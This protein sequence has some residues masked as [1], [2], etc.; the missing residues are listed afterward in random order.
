[1]K[2]PNVDLNNYKNI[3]NAISNQIIILDLDKNIVFM[4]ESA[5]SLVPSNMGPCLHQPCNC[6]HTPYC[7]TSDCCIERFLRGEEGMIQKGPDGIANRVSISELKNDQGERIGYISISTDIRE[8]LDSQRQLVINEERYKIALTQSKSIL[9]R[10]DPYDNT[11]ERINHSEHYNSNILSNDSVIE[12]IPDSLWE[13]GA[14]AQES[15]SAV[16]TITKNIRNGEKECECTIK[17]R[18]INGIDHWIHIISTTIF[19]E[20]GMVV[21]AIGISKDV[22]KEKQLELDY[23]EEK[24]YHD[25]ISSDFIS[26][27]E[28]DLTTNKVLNANQTWLRELN[29]EKDASYDDLQNA[30]HQLLHP[31]FHYLKAKKD[32]QALIECFQNGEKQVVCEYRKLVDGNYRWIRSSTKLFQH[33]TSGDIISCTSMK[34]IE[35]EKQREAEWRNK[36]ERDLLTGV[37]NHSTAVSL[38]SNQLQRYPNELHAFIIMDLD[39]F[40]DVNDTYGHLYG[41][42]VLTKVAKQLL[43]TFE[44]S[45]IGRLGGDEFVV[46][47]SCIYDKAKIV[48][49]CEALCER[50]SKETFSH[51]E[52]AKVSVSIGISYYQERMTTFDELYRKADIAMY[53]GKNNGKNQCTVYEE[54]MKE[55]NQ[56]AKVGFSEDGQGPIVGN[57]REFIFKNLFTSDPDEFE[58]T[59]KNTLKLIAIYFGGQHCFIIQCDVQLGEATMIEEWMERKEYAYRPHLSS[60]PKEELMAAILEYQK[61]PEGIMFANDTTK[62]LSSYAKAHIQRTKSKTMALM[63]IPVDS[64]NYLVIGFCDLRRTRTFT[65]QQKNDLKTIYEIIGIF[66]LNHSQKL[67]LSDHLHSMISLLDHIG[68][69]VYVIDPFDH[70]LIYFNEET[71]R[72]FPEAGHGHRCYSCF[73]GFDAPCADCPVRNLKEHQKSVVTIYNEAVDQWVRTTASEIDWPDGHHYILLSCVDVTSYKNR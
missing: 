5:K 65:R 58:R 47:L 33:K 73:R 10:Y 41:D 12:R 25:I 67:K 6:F 72:L 57:I 38:I 34:D 31:E 49:Q 71:A 11:I 1:M 39:N 27:Y 18:D 56:I 48:H 35:D 66:L 52:M 46:F 21:E 32:K 70:H 26:V 9:W 61:T 7:N 20:S 44:G 55:Y 4:N 51:Y 14:L 63:R 29:I 22:T 50:L 59:L 28:A 53:Y 8:L 69:A 19:D 54:Q 43:D 42:L 13:S 16:K 64:V 17:M 24:E 37:Y 2:I 40:K 68:N 30:I 60:L 23:R 45:V 15:I 3:L 62:N 36:A